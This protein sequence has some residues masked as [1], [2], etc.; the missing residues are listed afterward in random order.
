VRDGRPR[1]RTRAE[2]GVDLLQGL[3][4]VTAI[5]IARR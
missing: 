1:N 5:A 3:P 2:H 4:V